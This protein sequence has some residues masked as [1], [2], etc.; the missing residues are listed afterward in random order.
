MGNESIEHGI[1]VSSIQVLDSVIDTDSIP[2]IE[3]H[4][5]H[6]NVETAKNLRQKKNVDQ[7]F[8]ICKYI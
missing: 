1:N 4:E 2:M 3:I 8:F 5:Q 7:W 6:S